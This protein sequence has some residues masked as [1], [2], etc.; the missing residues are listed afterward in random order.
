MMFQIPSTVNKINKMPIKTFA[1]AI[2][3]LTIL[4]VNLNWALLLVPI[5]RFLLFNIR[6]RKDM[7]AIIDKVLFFTIIFFQNFQNA[8]KNILILE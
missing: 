2:Q 5:L 8:H 6:P 4:T 1:L 7:K 3:T